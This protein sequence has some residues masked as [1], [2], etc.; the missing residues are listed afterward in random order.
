MP[1]MSDAMRIRGATPADAEVITAFNAAMAL[2][3]EHKQLDPSVLRAG[4][5]AAIA[6]PT[7]SKY[8]LAEIEGR[9]VG[10]LMVTFEW[11]D[12]RNADFWWI[13]S[14]YVPPDSRPRGVFA[15][16]YRHVEQLARTA[17]ACGLRL[18]VERDNTGAQTAYRRLGMT[19]A[20]Y[21]VYETDWSVK[22]A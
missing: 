11:S 10:Q 16:L 8:F 1:A 3:T 12:W 17:G 20:G 6:R 5:E 2:E 7:S 18:Y 21:L 15:A 22:P 14:V 4:V 13:Q 19:D 9:V